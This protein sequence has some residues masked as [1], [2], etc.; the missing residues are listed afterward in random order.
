MGPSA[1][2]D[3]S[4]LQSLSVDESVWFDHFF[5]AIICPL[6]YVETLADLEKAVREDRTPEQEVGIIARKF[7]DMTGTPCVHHATAAIGELLGH[8]VPMTGQ[9]PVSGG[10]T[11]RVGDRTGVIF[12]RSVESEAFSRWQRGKFLELERGT[13]KRWRDALASIDLQSAAA[14]LRRDGRPV[15]P[16]KSLEEA[17]EVAC[18]LVDNPAKPLKLMNVLFST[19]DVRGEDQR[20]ILERWSIHGYRR[21]REYSPYAAHVVTVE[22]F[23]HLALSANLISPDRATNRV[24]ISYLHYLPFCDAFISSDSLHR[25]CA[26]PF[27]RADQVFVWG[28]DLKADLQRLNSHYLELPES[29]RDG[30]IPAFARTL[31]ANVAP[32]VEQIWDSTHPGWRK[33]MEKPVPPASPDMAEKILEDLKQFEEAP[34]IEGAEHLG[35]EPLASLTLKREYHKRKGSWYQVP[36]DI[37]TKAD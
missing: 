30:G 2:F 34:T 28:Q 23:F 7:P 36:K 6:F 24:D 11:K 27:L 14:A 12:E 22:V 21:L 35:D 26:P 32:L 4:F 33:N 17:H 25:R 15:T 13:A 31:P 37:D 1:L 8:A 29:I 16:C 19:L 20:A 18:S 5:Y 3:K 10:E 9:I